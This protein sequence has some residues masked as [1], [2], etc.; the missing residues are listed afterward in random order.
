[1]FGR[2]KIIK[3]YSNIENS[4]EEQ[5]YNTL[6][7]FICK[8]ELEDYKYLDNIFNIQHVSFIEYAL[9]YGR[10]NI[11][12][13]ILTKEFYKNE[14]KNPEYNPFDINNC[15]IN[16]SND[17]HDGSYWSN[18]E[19]ERSIV[20]SHLIKHE[21][22]FNILEK[23]GKTLNK[24]QFMSWYNLTGDNI[25]YKGG[26]FPTEIFLINKLFVQDKQELTIKSL[27]TI[28][29]PLFENKRQLVKIIT[30]V[31]NSDQILDELKK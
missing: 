3:D 5:R 2:R 24:E 25:Y 15:E 10:Y 30:K 7:Q 18:D 19:H 23:Y 29:E 12:E 4:T 8:G 6:I 1:M 11:L 16:I 27:I 9:V 21:E 28:F 20:N 26:Y 14:L 22:C 17:V 31:F 13:F